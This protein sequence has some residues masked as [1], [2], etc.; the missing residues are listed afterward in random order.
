MYVDTSAPIQVLRLTGLSNTLTLYNAYPTI[1]QLS[2]KLSVLLPTYHV[3][4]GTLLCMQSQLNL[5]GLDV[6]AYY[7]S[8]RHWDNILLDTDMPDITFDSS[9]C[10]GC[11][12]YEL[13]FFDTWNTANIL[14]LVDSIKTIIAFNNPV[15]GKLLAVYYNGNDISTLI[16]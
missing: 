8:A 4:K 3:Q 6:I 15:N 9:G 7:V 12:S 14:I 16:L 5:V 11:I 2:R 10:G 13:Y 1:I